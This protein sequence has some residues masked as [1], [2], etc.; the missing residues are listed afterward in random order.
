MMIV[1]GLELPENTMGT[2]IPNVVIQRFREKGIPLQGK[3]KEIA[4]T[5]SPDANDVLMLITLK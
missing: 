1:G 5:I 3:L 4:D 2:V